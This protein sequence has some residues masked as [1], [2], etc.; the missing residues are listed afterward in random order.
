[1]IS[2]QTGGNLQYLIY[3]N[4]TK[5]ADR[6]VTTGAPIVPASVGALMAGDTFVINSASTDATQFAWMTVY[7]IDQ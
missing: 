7:E 4:G 1:V 5:I 6:A 3:L 2:Q